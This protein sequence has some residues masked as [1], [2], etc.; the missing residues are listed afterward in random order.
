MPV[1]WSK[2]GIQGREKMI[3]ELATLFIGVVCWALGF[4]VAWILRDILDDS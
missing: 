4:T 2:H 3:S 1:L